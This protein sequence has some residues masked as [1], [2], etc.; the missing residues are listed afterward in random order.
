MK[1]TMERISDSP[2]IYI[3]RI[4]E[5]D[6]PAPYCLYAGAA[7]VIVNDERIALVKGFVCRFKYEEAMR[8]SIKEAFASVGILGATG[9]RRV[10]DFSLRAL[11]GGILRA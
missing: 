4:Y 8:Q 10:D 6:N 2:E 11:G 9:D 1:S 7:T 3:L 5:N